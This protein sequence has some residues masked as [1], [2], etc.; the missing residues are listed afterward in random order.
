MK[1]LSDWP[2]AQ[3]RN[4]I[5]VFTDIDDTLTTHGAITPD[6]LQALARLK[7]AGLCVIAITGRPVGWCEQIAA[8]LPVDAIVAENGAVALVR[9]FLAPNARRSSVTF[10]PAGTP[11]VTWL[12][13]VTFEPA[14]VKSKSVVGVQET[15]VNASNTL[16]KKV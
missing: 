13:I 15:G 5:G 4:I 8:S 10:V 9:H 14:M 6:A 2:L 12:L 3:R 7:S 16:P 1:P 11:P